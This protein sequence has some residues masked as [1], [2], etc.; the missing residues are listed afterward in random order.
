MR[1]AAPLR[2]LDLQIRAIGLPEPER[3][4]AGIPGRRYRFDRAW[5]DRRLALEYQG[6]AW[7]GGKSRHQTCVGV[8]QDAEK[9]N[10]ALLAGWRVLLVTAPHVASGQAIRWIEEA[11]R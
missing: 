3:E 4:Y 1:D 2:T 9:F 5:V 10:M 6:L 8:T 11:L 7:A